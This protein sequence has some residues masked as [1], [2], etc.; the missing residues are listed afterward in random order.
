M[1]TIESLDALYVLTRV[2]SHAVLAEMA[3]DAGVHTYLEKPITDT[4]EEFQTLRA[5]AQANHVVLYPGLSALGFQEIQKLRALS[6]SGRFGQLVTVHCDYNWTTPDGSIPYG[7]SDHW[8]YSMRGGILRNLA[9]HPMSILMHL[10][11]D[12]ETVTSIRRRRRPLPNDVHDL[13]HIGLGCGDQVGSMTMS[14]GHG[15]AKGI[16]ECYYERG[17]IVVDIHDRSLTVTPLSGRPRMAKRTVRNILNNVSQSVDSVIVAAR[18][19]AN[20]LPNPIAATSRNFLDV[21]DGTAPSF[22]D[23]DK[24]SR[25]IGILD[26]VWNAED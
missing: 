26:S 5:K 15:N 11:E 12:V 6:A 17:T 18:A 10:L 13:L 25:M 7:A 3:L 24:T 1:L 22:V 21:I 23:L 14:F 2:E 4:E 16:L 8:A 20:E 19:V 9:D